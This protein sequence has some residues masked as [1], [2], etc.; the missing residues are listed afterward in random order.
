MFFMSRKNDML[1]CFN[2]TLFEIHT[3]R[4][5]VESYNRL[6]AWK[7]E[8]EREKNTILGIHLSRIRGEY[9]QCTAHKSY[10]AM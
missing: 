3:Y 9:D 1:L 4:R 6:S 2:K 7:K 5:K 8:R 10:S